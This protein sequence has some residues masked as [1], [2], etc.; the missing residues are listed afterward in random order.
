MFVVL[1]LDRQKDRRTDENGWIENIG[2]WQL[3]IIYFRTS[4][5]KRAA[6]TS[7]IPFSETCYF[8]YNTYICNNVEE[9]QAI[10]CSRYCVYEVYT[11]MCI[12]RQ[13]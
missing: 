12:E 3:L 2:A 4:Q 7:Y 10:S 9:I 1:T 13:R 11:I 6:E 5:I 8:W